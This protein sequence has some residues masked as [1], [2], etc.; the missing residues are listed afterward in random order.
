MINIHISK[1]T[2]IEVGNVYLRNRSKNIYT[3]I[4][5][6]YF[7]NMLL[8]VINIKDHD[9]YLYPP[10]ELFEKLSDLLTFNDYTCQPSLKYFKQSFI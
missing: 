1:I 9:Q 4:H 10:R 7:T 8:T 3:C 6:K 5:V 2:F